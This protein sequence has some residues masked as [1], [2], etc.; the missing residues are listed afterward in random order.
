MKNVLFAWG[1]GCAVGG[2]I[3]SIANLVKDVREWLAERRER[4]KKDGHKKNP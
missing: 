3:L 1:M 2:L 4:K